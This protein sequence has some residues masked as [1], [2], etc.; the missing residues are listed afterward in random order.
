MLKDPVGLNYKALRKLTKLK[1]SNS[2]CKRLQ[3]RRIL[4]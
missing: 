4:K 3:N 2:H 1:I